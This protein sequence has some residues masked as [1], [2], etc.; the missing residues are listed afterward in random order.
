[1]DR[2]MVSP[3]MSEPVMMAVPS[4]E[5]AITSSASTG[6]PNAWRVERCRINGDRHRIT[7]NGID[8]ATNR[9]SDTIVSRFRRQIPRWRRR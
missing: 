4:S 3:T 7:A 8:S 2:L 5:P 6:R 1:M 9:N